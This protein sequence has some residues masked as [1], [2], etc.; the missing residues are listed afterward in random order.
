MA[1]LAGDPSQQRRL[2][3]A[4]GCGIWREGLDVAHMAFQAP[5]N[6]LP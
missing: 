4:I 2:I 1:G 6:S 3:V 5:R